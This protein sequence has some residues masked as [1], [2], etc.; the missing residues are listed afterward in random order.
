MWKTG[1][2]ADLRPP[3]PHLPWNCSSCPVKINES[4]CEQLWFYI[5]V[6]ILHFLLMFWSSS[7]LSLCQCRAAG[8]RP[9]P[10]Q[11][12]AS[13]GAGFWIHCAYRQLHPRQR[14]SECQNHHRCLS[15]SKSESKRSIPSGSCW[16]KHLLQKK[17]LFLLLHFSTKPHLEC[18]SNISPNCR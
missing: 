18:I 3:P 12:G 8:S 16:I 13:Q 6:V 14:S 11:W 4:T 15:S 7:T 17:F 9:G 1:K 5:Y 2:T 10:L